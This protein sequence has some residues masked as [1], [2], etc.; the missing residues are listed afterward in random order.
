MGKRI[1]YYSAMLAK[2]LGLDDKM[3]VA[4]KVTG[5]MHDIG[6]IGIPDNIL[7][8]TTP[9]TPEEW[10]IMQTHSALGTKILEN[11]T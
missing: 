11:C 1:S 8:K 9:F 10:S 5:Q 4:L 7:F 6:K 2:L 3:V